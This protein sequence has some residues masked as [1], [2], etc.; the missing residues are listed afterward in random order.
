MTTDQ[1]ENKRTF[2]RSRQKDLPSFADQEGTTFGLDYTLT[3]KINI[4]EPRIRNNT[5]HARKIVINDSSIRWEGPRTVSWLPKFHRS[6]TRNLTP[7]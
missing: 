2:S 4:Y 3:L 6:F 5:K 7:E 1:I